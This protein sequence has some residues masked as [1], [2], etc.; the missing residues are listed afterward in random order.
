MHLAKYML[1]SCMEIFYSARLHRTYSLC[2]QFA[3]LGVFFALIS[4]QFAKEW[5]CSSFWRSWHTFALRQLRM[6][7][8]AS[9]CEVRELAKFRNMEL[10]RALRRT[11]RSKFAQH[12]MM[13]INSPL[14]IQLPTSGLQVYGS[15]N[16]TTQE[17]G[18][19]KNKNVRTRGSSRCW[20]KY[21]IISSLSSL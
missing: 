21:W 10:F 12:R 2:A 1:M 15:S 9:N 11:S 4:H 18:A 5:S 20:H 8:A 13:A 6:A 17:P 16:K 3:Q 14:S 7:V 19:G